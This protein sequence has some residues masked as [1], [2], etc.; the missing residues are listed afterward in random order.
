MDLKGLSGLQRPATD[1]QGPQKRDCYVPPVSVYWNYTG[2]IILLL[3]NTVKWCSATI[4]SLLKKENCVCL[5]CIA[6]FVIWNNDYFIFNFR[7]ALTYIK[8]MAALHSEGCPLQ[9]LAVVLWSFALFMWSDVVLLSYHLA[10]EV[11][12]SNLWLGMWKLLFKTKPIIVTW[13]LFIYW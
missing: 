12:R 8:E 3:D 2:F 4:F 6:W 7:K 9:V 5:I 1:H 10:L 13:K 11:P